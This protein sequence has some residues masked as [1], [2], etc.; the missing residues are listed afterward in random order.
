VGGLD[1]R[2]LVGHGGLELDL[3]LV[4]DGLGAGDPVLGLL[5]DA[6]HRL[7]ALRLVDARDDVQGEVE[8]ALEVARADVEQDAEAARRALEVPDVTDG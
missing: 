7:L 4:D 1:L 8:D 5:V 6:L 3:L 2:A